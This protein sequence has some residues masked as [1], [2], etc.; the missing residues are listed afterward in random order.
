MGSGAMGK[1]IPVK[2]WDG[3]RC[4]GKVY[5]CEGVGWEDYGTPTCILSR[6]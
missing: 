2:G 6:Y 1:C 3:K 5:T 4:Y